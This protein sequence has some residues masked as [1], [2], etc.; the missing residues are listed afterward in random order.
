MQSLLIYTWAE[1]QDA[2]VFLVD[3]PL[4]RTDK[5]PKEMTKRTTTF[6]PQDSSCQ[7]KCW[8][9]AVVEIQIFDVPYETLLVALVYFHWECYGAIDFQ[10][11]IL[12]LVFHLPNIMCK[13]LYRVLEIEKVY[14][15]NG[16]RINYWP[17]YATV[18]DIFT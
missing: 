5:T 1:I 9:L 3:L 17:R 16:K 15:A 8:L 13:F 7:H 18:P 6:P 4:K 12:T 2:V 11:T 10:P 14:T